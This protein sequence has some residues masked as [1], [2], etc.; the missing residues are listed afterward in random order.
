[1]M[2]PTG[3]E[4]AVCGGL[5][6]VTKN[7]A[8][9]HPDFGKSFP[10][11][12]CTIHEER[13]HRQIAK[14]SNL[15]THADKHFGNFLNRI[16]TYTDDEN[17]QLE[18]AL[19]MAQSFA[20]NPSRWLVLS[21]RCGTGKTHLA[22]AIGHE[23]IQQGI[24]TIFITTP[25]LL[26]HLRSAF[27]PSA[28][29]RYDEQFDLL[30]HVDILILDDL[31]AENQTAWAQEKLYQLINHRY[32]AALPTI[33]TSNVDPAR[34]D[35][36]IASRLADLNRVM[37]VKLELPDY[38]RAGEN[39]VNSDLK[40]VSNLALY[41]N[42]TF[43]SFNT[44]LPHT[45]H[46]QPVVHRLRRY[47]DAPEGRWMIITGGIGAGKTH[48][49]AA[50]A[51]LWN[52]HHTSD[53]LMVNTTDLLDVL[54]ATF[55]PETTVSFST[56][57]QMIRQAWGLVLDDFDVTVRTPNWS[58]E[59]LFQLIDYR[60]LS[61]LPTVFTTSPYTMQQL[62]D[63]SPSL[64]SRLFDRDLVSTAVLEGTQDFRLTGR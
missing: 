43:E 3:T 42:K 15:E 13:R 64:Y 4:C 49:G 9:D 22:A 25:D 19:H 35:E 27:S 39:P 50:I 41:A 23:F 12:A 11:P 38:R 1:M 48:L 6:I 29:V 17:H 2:Y 52:K 32:N 58:R 36:R 34:M 57:F 53:T 56:R 16:E 21:G 37:T 63:I 24:R 20:R 54:K 10:C 30:C 33:I 28:E 61:R 7:V 46:L 62:K 51:N 26:D 44:A 8:L 47:A 60:Y 55:E 45:A 59:K 40:A 18:M 31:G 14:M 5:G